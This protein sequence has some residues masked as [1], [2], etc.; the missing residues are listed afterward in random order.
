MR[1]KS[2]GM[3]EPPTAL[4][5]SN[6]ID[7]LAIATRTPA[8][9]VYET[10]AAVRTGATILRELDN[11]TEITHFGSGGCGVRPAASAPSTGG[12]LANWF[13]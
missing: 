11:P 8:T 13:W 2:F 6:W 7:A 5:S 10:E 9:H 12:L 4:T 1:Y 3:A